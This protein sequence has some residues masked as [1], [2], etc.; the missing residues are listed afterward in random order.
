MKLSKV[1]GYESEIL[2]FTKFTQEKYVKNLISGQLFMNNIKYFIDLENETKVK[3]QGDKYEASNVLSNVTFKMM[4]QGTDVLIGEGT[5]EQLIERNHV[6]D[7][8]PIFCFT[9]FGSNDF[10]IV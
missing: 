10:K 5:A 9:A 7:N 1:K 6:F 4:L 3:G 8:I 2:L